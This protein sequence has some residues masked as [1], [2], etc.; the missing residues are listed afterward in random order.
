MLSI[1]S[2]APYNL[3]INCGAQSDGAQR[4]QTSSKKSCDIRFQQQS[5]ESSSLYLYP[6]HQNTNRKT[7]FNSN[8]P[9]KWELTRTIIQLITQKRT[10]DKNLL[11]PT[12]LSFSSETQKNKVSEK[13]SL[14]LHFLFLFL[15]H[16]GFRFLTMVAGCAEQQTPGGNRQTSEEESVPATR[17]SA[18]ATL[19]PL[20]YVPPHPAALLMKM[21]RI[22]QRP[23]LL[24]REAANQIQLW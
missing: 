23:P 21:L 7:I 16:L 15:V 1:F 2:M 8:F 19:L 11:P 5:M 14:K 18:M 24:R 22:G 9:L 6:K 3:N 20:Q 10:T 4:Q 17:V 13:D 12:W